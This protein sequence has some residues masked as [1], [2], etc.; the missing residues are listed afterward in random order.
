MRAK[1]SELQK[2][3]FLS[4]FYKLNNQG[5]IETKPPMPN[6]SRNSVTM[7]RYEKSDDDIAR[8]KIFLKTVNGGGTPKRVRDVENS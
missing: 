8:K 6:D 5:R 7:S 3:Q 4:K 1:K 2:Q